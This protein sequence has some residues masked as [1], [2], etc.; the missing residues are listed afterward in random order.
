ERV[1]AH[2]PHRRRRGDDGCRAVVTVHQQ[3]V[4]ADWV[5]AN[6]D[7]LREAAE[8]PDASSAVE[9]AGRLEGHCRP[10]QLV[11]ELEGLGVLDDSVSLSHDAKDLA[12]VLP[13]VGPPTLNLFTPREPPVVDGGDVPAID[14]DGLS[15]H[16]P[17]E[18]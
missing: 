9:A 11:D 4:R 8:D 18:P 15:L 14:R 3:H 12:G 17:T 13:D 2:N 6:L 1:H 10:D 7:V 16:A 5:T